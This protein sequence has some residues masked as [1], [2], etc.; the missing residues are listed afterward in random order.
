M[1]HG[2]SHWLSL[3]LSALSCLT[4]CSPRLAR[5]ADAP[6]V[7]AV[8]DQGP[9]ARPRARPDSAVLDPS[10]LYLR[11]ALLDAMD[12]RRVPP[13]EDVNAHDE[14]VASSWFRPDLARSEAELTGLPRSGPPE[15]PLRFAPEPPALMSGER[16][17][18]DAR[19]VRYRVLADPPGLAEVPST[20]A[21]VASLLVRRL[22]YLTPEVY[23]LSARPTDVLADTPAAEGEAA[24]L[25]EG[26]GGRV[27]LALT[28]WEGF[29][30]LGATPGALPRAD[31]PNDRVPHTARR[32]LRVFGVVAA[33]LGLRERGPLSFRDLFVRDHVLHTVGGLSGAFG[34]ADALR[35][36]E[37]AEA[38]DAPPDDPL[39][40]LWTLGLSRPP[41][42]Q[43]PGL[44]WPGA[45]DA[46]LRPRDGQLSPPLEAVAHAG[47]DDV[48]WMAKRMAGVR[49]DE[50]RAAV[51][52]ARLSR[53]E[54]ADWLVDTLIARRDELVAR[55][56]ADVTPFEPVDIHEDGVVLEDRAAQRPCE[57]PE[58]RALFADFLDARGARLGRSRALA[59]AG[60]RLNV[61]FPEAARG[62]EYVV[63][64]ATVVRGGRAAPRPLELHWVRSGAGLRVVGIRH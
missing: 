38:P 30:D 51:A 35:R 63:L 47:P 54:V 1:K 25:F 60:A 27:R 5:F 14:V 50:L 20:A 44:H 49:D 48:Y 36:H 46:L 39:R 31:D 56:F 41:T 2:S 3:L 4:G 19:G 10:D 34:V 33:W 64:R 22:G 12:P 52:A 40:Q 62:A 45:F 9:I 24:A 11:F 13:A 16:W 53:P 6:V 23:V 8:H 61:P 18:S 43:P 32:S 26:S 59:S 29:A 15:L 42:E 17:M 55:A 57:Q 7:R 58:G 21:V 28:A 37:G